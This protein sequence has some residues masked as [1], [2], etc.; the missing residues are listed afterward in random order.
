MVKQEKCGFVLWS[1]LEIIRMRSG[2]Y[3]WNE[4]ECAS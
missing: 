2:W 4:T 3:G 1:F